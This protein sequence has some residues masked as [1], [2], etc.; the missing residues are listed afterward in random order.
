MSCLFYS[1]HAL[2]APY[3]LPVLVKTFLHINIRIP[4]WTRY[5]DA[6]RLSFQPKEV[7]AREKIKNPKTTGLSLEPGYFFA[8]T[9]PTSRRGEEMLRQ[10]PKLAGFERPVMN[11]A[12]PGCLTCPSLRTQ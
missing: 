8:V 3:R 11:K 4:L 6:Q 9:T 2:R 5:F 1:K 7:M 10:S 12:S